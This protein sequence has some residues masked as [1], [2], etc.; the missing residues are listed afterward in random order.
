MDGEWRLERDYEVVHCDV[1]P[2]WS[3]LR[4]TSLEQAC[5]DRLVCLTRVPSKF[6]C[7][8]F[9]GDVTQ[10]SANVVGGDRLLRQKRLREGESSTT[11]G[12]FAKDTAH[13]KAWGIISYEMLSITSHRGYSKKG[14]ED[15]LS[16][17]S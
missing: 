11:G 3:T 8:A 2:F 14:R 9:E 15:S 13:G 4:L 6:E 12:R 1:V 16:L 7:Y 5:L 17:D 10:V